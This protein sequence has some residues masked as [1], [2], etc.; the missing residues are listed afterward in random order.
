MTAVSGSK[1][2]IV[3]DEYFL[4]KELERFFT[5]LGATVLGPF[6]T[7]EDAGD[8]V[9]E[10]DAAI[11]DV[12]VDGDLVFPL[13]DDLAERRIPF[14][15][16]TGHSE[17]NIPERFRYAGYL[18][19]PATFDAVFNALFPIAADENAG[20]PADGTVLGAVPQL[21]LAARLHLGD[22]GAADRLVELTLEEAI[23]RAR[24]KPRELPVNVWLGRLMG[25]VYQREGSKLL[26]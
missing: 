24:A 7:M 17:V 23:G 12:Y 3:E 16:Y 8:R 9:E 18:S 4:A 21:R 20:A 22:A 19:K 26:N 10:A 11:L 5:S 2:L 13:A 6:P 15:F 1:V 14:V 25:E